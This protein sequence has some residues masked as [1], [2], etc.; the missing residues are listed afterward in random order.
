[1][2]HATNTVEWTIAAHV[3]FQL[4]RYKPVYHGMPVRWW[5][6]L[7]GLKAFLSGATVLL[8][9]LERTTIEK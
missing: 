6:Y 1:M 4:A 8:I 2:N 3:S 7:C 9:L 5:G